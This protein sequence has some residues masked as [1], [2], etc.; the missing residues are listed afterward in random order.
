M[1]PNSVC[2]DTGVRMTI[3]IDDAEQ[4][5]LSKYHSVTWSFRYQYNNFNMPDALAVSPWLVKSL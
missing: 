2:T 1:T 5:I 4:A 3:D